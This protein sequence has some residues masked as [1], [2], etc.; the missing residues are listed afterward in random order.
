MNN[1]KTQD[2]LFTIKSLRYINY[3]INW[4]DIPKGKKRNSLI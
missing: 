1:I 4:F 3:T 2:K